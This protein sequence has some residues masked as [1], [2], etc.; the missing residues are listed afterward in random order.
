MSVTEEAARMLNM[1]LV[2]EFISQ[3][4]P[5]FTFSPSSFIISDAQVGGKSYFD[6]V[7][8][9][10][11]IGIIPVVYGDVI[12]DRK[13]GCTIFSTEKILSILAKELLKDYKVRIIYCTNVD[14]VY[15]ANGET[16]KEI[17][18]KNFKNVKKSIL[19]AGTTDV[20]GGML[21]K[22]EQS[23]ELATKTGIETLIINGEVEGELK[24]AI[25][26]KKVKGTQITS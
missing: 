20:T 17:Y 7:R 13:I 4:L 12:L 21:H 11:Q 8:K 16:I 9:A 3:R 24:R 19:G 25:L 15:D 14:G 6:P 2:K 10:L 26:R 23:L 5:V 1:I 18:S 22:V